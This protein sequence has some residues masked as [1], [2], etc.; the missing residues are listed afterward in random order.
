MFDGNPDELYPAPISC[1]DMP[2]PYDTGILPLHAT[3]NCD[4]E[5]TYEI[6]MAFMTSG[7]CPGTYVRIWNAYDDC[8]K[9]AESAI[10]YVATVDTL[11]PEFDFCPEDITVYLD[12]N[13]S[14]D[15][16]TDVTGMA[17][18]TDNCDASPDVWHEDISFMDLPSA[19]DTDGADY[20]YGNDDGE[21]NG[22]YQFTRVFYA[23]DMC[24]NENY[25][26]NSFCEHTIAVARRDRSDH[27]GGIGRLTA[28]RCS[29]QL[30]TLTPA[31]TW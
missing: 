28:R 12:E 23:E 3:D 5:L 29:A 18:V 15:L 27:D 16:S 7:S 13:C 31:S 1:G 20:V 25:K 9:Q 14:T 6:S 8:G 11:A 19:C 24:E 2:D 17:T 4:S 30:A 26:A 22:S 10:Q 21:H